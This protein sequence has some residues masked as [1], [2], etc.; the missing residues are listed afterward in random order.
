M[1]YK[2]KYYNHAMIPD[3]A[4]HE[5]PEVQA[6]HEK[7]FWKSQKGIVCLARWTSQF[8]CENET[9]WWYIILD[10]PFYLDNIKAKHR[11]QIKQGLKNFCVRQIDFEMY[12]KDILYI[13][14][15]VRQQ[16]YKRRKIYDLPEPADNEIYL[17]AFT[18]DTGKLVGYATLIE[19]E[20]YIEFSVLKVLP[21]YEKKSINAAIVY[22]CIMRYNEKLGEIYI[23]NGSRTINHQT[24]FDDYLI[25]MFE[26]RKAYCKLFIK[27]R[28]WFKGIV[29]VL[30]PWKKMVNKSQGNICRAISGILKMEEIA[31]AQ[32]Y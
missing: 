25:R 11:Y 6:L 24:M 5:E 8:D 12:K 20:E 21:E 14:N 29:M 1:K 26:F 18:M 32:K 7:A 16:E 15:F 31:N 27:Y 13:L 30:K 2:W 22:N 17:G 28:W 4:P 19:H 10:H 3:S 23:T 9:Q